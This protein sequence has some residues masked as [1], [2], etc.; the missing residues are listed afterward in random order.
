MKKKSS[1][2][3]NV[4]QIERSTDVDVEKHS[5]AQLKKQLMIQQ[6]SL[7]SDSDISRQSSD[8]NAI[9]TSTESFLSVGPG[10]SPGSS[11]QS[12]Q[13][14]RTANKIEKRGDSCLKFNGENDRL[15]TKLERSQNVVLKRK[16]SSSLFDHKTETKNTCGKKEASQPANRYRKSTDPQIFA[17]EKSTSSSSSEYG[18]GFQYNRKPGRYQRNNFV[19]R[20]S[21]FCRSHVK[22]VMYPKKCQQLLPLEENTHS[23]TLYLMKKLMKRGEEMIEKDYTYF[24]FHSVK[25]IMACTKECEDRILAISC[26]DFENFHKIESKSGHVSYIIDS[27]DGFLPPLGFDEWE[28][29]ELFKQQRDM[30]CQRKKDENDEFVGSVYMF[31]SYDG[32]PVRKEVS[33]RKFNTCHVCFSDKLYLTGKFPIRNKYMS[34]S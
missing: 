16:S 28:C 12:N 11:E 21:P 29:L 25:Q 27:A 26:E 20:K 32:R 8:Q 31:I 19:N 18:N 34:L 6:L 3:N 5:I 1:D 9:K 15:R 23:S 13:K 30:V 24:M 2:S 22:S 33:E 17:N 10:D 14:S 7:D 4:N